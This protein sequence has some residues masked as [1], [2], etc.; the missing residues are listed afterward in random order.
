MD[1]TPYYS[2]AVVLLSGRQMGCF[3]TWWHDYFAWIKSVED[4]METLFEEHI[5]T[6]EGGTSPVEDGYYWC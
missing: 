5:K 4:G 2:A 3:G 1:T 6:L